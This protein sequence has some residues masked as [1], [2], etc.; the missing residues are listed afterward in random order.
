[1]LTIDLNRISRISTQGLRVQNIA[2]LINERSLKDAHA[3]MDA[4][5][6]T[7]VDRVTKEKYGQNLTKNLAALVNRMKG[8]TYTPNPSR[9]IYIDKP[10]TKKKRPLG[11]S[12]YEDKLVEKVIAEILTAIYEPK[13]LDCSFGFRPER[14]CHEAISTCLHE[15]Q[16]Q[17]SYIVEADI[18]SCF[19]RLSHARIIEFLEHDIADRQFMEII[20]RFLKA[21]YV[22]DNVWHDAET[23]SPQGSGFSPCIANVYLH[24]VLDTWFNYLKNHGHFKGDAWIVRYADDFVCGFQYASDANVFYNTLPKRFA[25]FGLE[26][27]EEKTRIIEFGRFAES[28]CLKRHKAEPTKRRKP[29]TFDFLGFT[30]YCGKSSRTGKFTPKVKS[31]GKRMR[32]KLQKMEAWIKDNRHLPLRDV[33]QHINQVLEGYFA[34]YAVSCNL[35]W[36][37]KF[38][39]NI[40]KMLYK[41]LNRRSQR[42]SYTWPGFVDMLNDIPILRAKVRVDIY[43]YIFNR[44]AKGYRGA[45]CSN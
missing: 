35:L 28:N 39:Y 8:G 31:A 29:E 5:K 1:M 18:R 3:A 17:T 45:V 11:I 15:I 44:K 26:L 22:E 32:T 10:G 25:K 14:N 24:Y 19:D 4:K 13:F 2:C 21:G 42:R 33:I 23:G 43:G 34:Y 9:R 40:I 36:V 30:F 41:W 12:C 7:G 37:C 27:A 38:R 6:A 20:K 16:Q